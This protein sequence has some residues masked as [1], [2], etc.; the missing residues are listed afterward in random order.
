M[1]AVV[2]DEVHETA[3]KVEAKYGAVL[4]SIVPALF[5]RRDIGI[6]ISGTLLR[7]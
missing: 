3:M 7:L 6:P 1:A 4:D 5:I 2:V